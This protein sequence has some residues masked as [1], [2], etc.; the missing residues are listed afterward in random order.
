MLRKK[1]LIAILVSVVVITTGVLVPTVMLSGDSHSM[2]VTRMY[3]DSLEGPWSMTSSS[4]TRY[5]EEITVVD[6][7]TTIVI[8]E[9]DFMWE[10]PEGTLVFVGKKGAKGDTGPQGPK[11]AD[12]T[13]PNNVEAS[14]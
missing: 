10:A 13:Y 4:T 2:S 14:F 9:A 3:A 12:C 11:G 5:V 6:G 7:Q 8:Q 1:L